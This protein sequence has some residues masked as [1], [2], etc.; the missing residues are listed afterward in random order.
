MYHDLRCMYMIIW[1]MLSYVI[2]H[3]TIF[4]LLFHEGVIKCRIRDIL[5]YTVKNVGSTSVNRYHKKFRPTPPTS[6]AL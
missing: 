4:F 1:L 6:P 2:I 3:G 5:P